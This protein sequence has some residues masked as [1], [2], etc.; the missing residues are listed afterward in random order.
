MRSNEI[1]VDDI[2]AVP[3]VMLYIYAIDSDYVRFIK[4]FTKMGVTSIKQRI[5][6]ETWDEEEFGWR[7]Y[8]RINRYSAIRELF[9]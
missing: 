2:I 7:R 3:G 6:I 8:Y 5:N 9:Q 4:I 1:E